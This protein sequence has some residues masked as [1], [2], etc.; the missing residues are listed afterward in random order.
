MKGTYLRILN[1]EIRNE[2]NRQ[3]YPYM[4]GGEFVKGRA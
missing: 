2:L 1:R 3:R 4:R